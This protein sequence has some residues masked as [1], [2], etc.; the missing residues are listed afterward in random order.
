MRSLGDLDNG[1][2]SNTQTWY[3]PDHTLS[4]LTQGDTSAAWEGISTGWFYSIL[5][6]GYLRR[7]YRDPTNKIDRSNLPSDYFTTHRTSV[8][9]DNT[10]PIGYTGQKAFRD[11][12]IP[13][14]F[15]G[16][17][18]IIT[19]RLPSQTIPGWSIFNGQGSEITQS[20]LVKWSDI[21]V[22]NLDAGYPD[23]YALMLSSNG[24]VTHNN[25]VVPDWGAL[26]FDLHT[27]NV[28]PNGSGELKVY[29][30]AIDGTS[31]EQ[32]IYLKDAIGTA[33]E[34]ANDRW[35]I[36][37]G[38]TGFETFTIDIPDAFRGKVATLKFELIGG[39]TVYLDNVFF[40]SQH[41]LLGN[42]T[43]SR[44]SDIAG[45]SSNRQPD[46]NNYLIEK[47]QYTV[48]YND[49]TK[50]PNWVSWELNESWLG[51][52]SRKDY[53]FEQDTQLSN[54]WYQTSHSDYNG[55]RF[56]ENG[57]SRA[58]QQGHITPANDRNW[59]AK[60]L[61]STF[62]GTNLIAQHP[63]NNKGLWRVFEDFSN[64]LASQKDKHLYVIAGSYGTNSITPSFPTSD[65]LSTITIPETLWK[66][67]VILDNPNQSLADLFQQN[68]SSTVNDR[69]I[70]IKVP[71]ADTANGSYSP[72]WWNPSYRTN[73]R[74]LEQELSRATNTTYNFLSN[75]PQEVQ[76]RYEKSIYSG[77]DSVSAF[78]IAEPPGNGSA[79]L[80]NIGISDRAIGQNSVI[81]N[82][83][84]QNEWFS[85]VHPIAKD[86]ISQVS[87]TKVGITNFTG[88]DQVGTSQISSDKLSL[89]QAGPTQVSATQVTTIEG[90]LFQPS[91]TEVRSPQIS[92]AEVTLLQL[93]IDKY[94]IFQTNSSQIT[95]N[96]KQPAIT[97]VSFPASV[98]LQQFFDS[99]IYKTH[100]YNLQN[101]TIPTWT[102][103]IQGTTPFNLNIEITDL[104]TG[105]LAE[106]S[107]TGYDTFGRP[108]SGTLT[109]DLDGNGLGWFI[110]TTPWENSEFSTQTSD[111]TSTATPGSLAYGRY[112]LLTTILHELGHLQ[113]IISGNPAFDQYVQRNGNTLRFIAP[114]INALLTPDGSHLDSSAHPNS[115]MNTTLRPGMRKLPTALDLAILNAIWGS[116]LTIQNSA[117]DLSSPLTA[118][119]LI[120][121]NNGSFDTSTDWNTRGDSEILNGHAILSED[122]PYQSNFSQTFVVPQGA[123]A[124]QF[125]LLS[126]DLHRSP[127]TPGD[128]FEAALLDTRTGNSVVNFAAGLSNTDAFLNL[129]HNGQAYFSNQVKLVGATH[130][131]DTLALNAPRTIQVDLTG[132]TPGTVV[133]LYLDL[134]GF[135]TRDSN[136]LIDD[137]RLLS[138]L[139]AAPIATN[140][141]ASVTYNS[142]SPIAI[143]NNDRDPDGTLN[144]NTLQILSQPQNG[145]V[146]INNDGTVN[147][148]PNA[149][150]LG[151]DEFIYIVQDDSG[152]ISNSAKVSIVVAN[153]APVIEQIT[154]APTLSEGTPAQYSATASVSTGVAL[155]YEWS[156]SDGSILIQGQTVNHTY[157]D[158]DTYPITLTVTVAD[159][160]PTVASLTVLN[161]L[162]EGQNSTLVSMRSMQV[163]ISSPTC[164]TSATAPLPQT[165]PSPMPTPHHP[166]WECRWAVRHLPNPLD[167]LSYRMQW[168]PAQPQPQTPNQ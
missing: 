145:K 160:L 81:E 116:Q 99:N 38:E 144:P 77:P 45:D 2:Y 19:E 29:L 122:S 65:G 78:L 75:L 163:T 146:T 84:I 15:N 98:A 50:T 66:V 31:K 102:Q 69:V 16:D 13:T 148:T 83:I 141:S 55:Q 126:T 132:V 26:R 97:K 28:E 70:A 143:L 42:P 106:A 80:G 39:G 149:G 63:S 127:L 166:F 167:V 118:G 9:V 103:F 60:D 91:S 90:G 44:A 73:V 119:A 74:D 154:I 138:E 114:G 156:F 24:S 3:T 88:I 157:W 7:P 120:G 108:N 92:P 72:S 27:G 85:L 8:D 25:F 37:Y 125:T 87:P 23:N 121:I 124:L 142:S 62:L 6:G 109:L 1:G 117:S 162:I 40:K 128:T 137:V 41:L 58:W 22:A 168:T 32:T 11:G 67:V 96:I 34:Y 93:G 33:P 71:N 46:E 43:N 150:F 4:Q 12:A 153:P 30:Q 68:P 101:T 139:S 140:D 135:G 161:T 56:T 112:D 133:T 52:Q 35:R 107:L 159:L 17:F 76:D 54:D 36:G 18:D 104:P 49:Q 47:P 164:G 113:G 59:N 5:G 89:I 21:R 123:K 51:S 151:H 158:S 147:Y 82:G 129:Q 131:G 64:S 115:L 53:E 134:L 61:R 20:D 79:Q 111:Y 57:T 10:Y 155:T 100:S 165:P 105:Q 48:S 110:D 94:G 95:V 86:R 136:V 130:S 152:V 14:F